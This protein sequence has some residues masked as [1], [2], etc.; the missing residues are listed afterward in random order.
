MIRS[1]F[2]LLTAALAAIV[3]IPSCIYWHFR[4][5]KDQQGAYRKATAIC[6]TWIRPLMAIA[7][8]NLHKKGEETL[9]SSRPALYVGNHQGDMDILLIMREFG[10][11]HSIIAKIETKK[12]PIVAQWMDNADCLFMDRG[13]PRQTLAVIKQAQEL[14]EKGRSVVVFPEGTRS[15]GPEMNEF[16][17]G[18]LRC[19]VKAGVPIVPF[20]IDGSYKVFEQ[21]RYLKKADVY[22]HILPAIQPE[23]FAGMK[24]PDLSALVQQQI[25]EELYRLRAEA[26]CETPQ[27]ERKAWNTPQNS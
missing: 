14:L 10:D 4:R 24:T 26:G 7:G 12:I 25:Q 22:F 18:A 20:V 13:N 21:Q 17:P 23:S 3:N 5:G 15:Q 16:K 9:D 8:V 2:F 1:I 6:H 19:A 27:E 11:L